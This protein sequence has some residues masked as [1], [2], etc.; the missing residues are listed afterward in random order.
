MKWRGGGLANGEVAEGDVS[1]IVGLGDRQSLRQPSRPIRLLN[2]ADEDAARFAVCF[3]HEVQTI[4]HPVDQINISM[5]RRAEDDTGGLGEASRRMGGQVARAQVGLG[6]GDAPRGCAMHDYFAKQLPRDSDG[7]PRIE[8]AGQNC[9]LD[10]IF[11]FSSGYT[12]FYVPMRLFTAINLDSATKA[13]LGALLAKVK[14]TAK[15]HWT[16]V[17]N[18]HI[19]TKFIGEWEEE[20][21]GQLESALSKVTVTGPIRIGLRGLG[22]FPNPHNPRSFWVGINAGDQLAALAK[23]TNQALADLGI[24]TETKAF[25]PHLT[26]ARIKGDVDLRPLRSAIVELP[27]VD[28]GEFE[29]RAFHLYLSE[30]HSFGSVYKKIGEFPLIK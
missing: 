22:W 23:S 4:V 11:H 10:K 7:V 3:N 21:L 12:D 28:F 14:P 26:L 5:T 19:T 25:S 13:R 17:E 9:S 20:R 6:F 1:P 24:A 18:L 8:I 2:G 15:L 29:A 30:L 16:P 27:S